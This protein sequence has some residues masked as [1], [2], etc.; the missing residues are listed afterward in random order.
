MINI[1]KGNFTKKETDNL[2]KCNWKSANLLYYRKIMNQKKCNRQIKIQMKITLKYTNPK[3]LNVRPIVASAER[4][5]Q[6][7]SQI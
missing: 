1:H 7:L 5:T 4:T 3:N 2:N 6:R